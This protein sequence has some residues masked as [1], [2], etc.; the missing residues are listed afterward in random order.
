MPEYSQR[1]GEL[2]AE[3][4][5]ELEV[6]R[7]ERPDEDELK[8]LV[9]DYDVLIIGIKEKMT[10]EVFDHVK[11]LKILGTITNGVDHI[12]RRFFNSPHIEVMNCPLASAS[13]V[14]EHAFGL[15]LALQKRLAEG[16]DC[17]S[18]GS[19]S[20]GMEGLP[21]DLRG[22]KLGVIGAGHIGR[23]VIRLGK[24]FQME[25][26]CHTFNPQLYAGVYG[27]TVA[28]TSLE[29]LLTESDIVSLHMPLLDK[30]RNLVSAG[31][32]NMMKK[33]GV[34]INTSREEI[35]DTGHLIRRAG[36]Y[37]GFRVGLDIDTEHLPGVFDEKRYNVIVTPHIAGDSPEARG[38]TDDELAGRIREYL[39]RN[40]F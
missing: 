9:R 16:N 5:V 28:F 21:G 29:A 37:P 1:A 32:I 12:S 38:R 40:G 14:A 33:D 3:C 36:K 25:I 26:C 8:G 23:E 7:G 15:M 10:D 2:L 39:C 30:T 31:N 20:R 6:N 24:A 34:F 4:G 11:A 27:E 13:S 22:K 17:V 18:S 19:G 35:A